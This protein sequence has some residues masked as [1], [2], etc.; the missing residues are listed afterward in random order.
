MGSGLGCVVIWWDEVL[1]PVCFSLWE[2]LVPQFF[3]FWLASSD[4]PFRFVG[5]W[6]CCVLGSVISW[7]FDFYLG[8]EW[9]SWCSTNCRQVCSYCASTSQ[10]SG[11]SAPCL[12]PRRSP[13]R[14]VPAAAMLT[15][16]LAVLGLQAVPGLTAPGAYGHVGAHHSAGR[17]VRGR[18][19]CFPCGLE[20]VLIFQL[21]AG[22]NLQPAEAWLITLIQ[23]S[24]F[25]VS[26]LSFCPVYSNE[27]SFVAF[28]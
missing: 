17:K 1:S 7:V 4:S 11:S 21:K 2:Q 25:L 9:S 8:A 10:V 26:G 23:R 16:S 15:L 3:A 27:W 24:A 13:W 20:A 5:F 14:A 19:W 28:T 18:A 6:C 22:G 12:A